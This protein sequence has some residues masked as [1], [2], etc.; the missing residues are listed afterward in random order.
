MTNGGQDKFAGSGDGELLRQYAAGGREGAF[1]EVVRRHVDWVY[2]AAV[3]VTRDPALAEDVT[4]GVFVALARKAGRLAR[5]PAVTGWLFQAVRYGAAAAVRRER[6]RRRHEAQAMMNGRTA[7]GA[8]DGREVVDWDRVAG[9]L[10]AA[11]ARLREGDREAI[12]LRYYRRLNWAEVGA[13]LGVTEDAARMRVARATGRLRDRLT[14]A[15][16][17]VGAGEAGVGALTAGLLV[18]AVETAPAR[19]AHVAAGGGAVGPGAAAVSKGVLAMTAGKVQG[20]A[21][22]VV[23]AALAAGGV[24]V[25][26]GGGGVPRPATPAAVPAG[27]VVAATASAALPVVPIGPE[28]TVI[29]GPLRADGRVDY[30]AALNAR[31]GAGVT[32]ENNGYVLWLKAVGT[33]PDS[34][35][36]AVREQVLAMA[37]AAGAPAGDALVRF[38]VYAESHRQAGGKEGIET[39][40]ALA[41]VPWREADAPVAAAYL[42]AYDGVLSAAAAAVRRPRWWVP[43]VAEDGRGLW[44]ASL[45]STVWSSCQTVRQGLLARATRRLAAGDF[46][47]FRGDVLSARWVARR[48]AETPDYVARTFAWG[49]DAAA[50]ETVA[51]MAARGLFSAAECEA[52]ATDFDG[53]PP[54]AGLAEAFDVTARWRVLDLFAAGKY[55]AWEDRKG[56]MMNLVDTSRF[57]DGESHSYS[58]VVHTRREGD[59]DWAAA[60]RGANKAIDEALQG[61]DAPSIAEAKRRGKELDR[62]TKTAWAAAQADGELTPAAGESREAYSERFGRLLAMEMGPSGSRFWSYRQ[63]GMRTVMARVLLGAAGVKARTGRWPAAL[64]EVPAAELGVRPA[65]LAHERVGYEVTPAGPRVFLLGGDGKEEAGNRNSVGAVED[66]PVAAPAQLP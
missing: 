37:G 29:S 2:S 18:H 22:G 12:L 33:G 34:M 58:P 19:V 6:V 41:Q 8:V 13:A 40:M 39:F 61:F 43:A 55:E 5:H 46:D 42:R 64:A 36:P 57:K 11:V 45:L 24:A 4:Q 31:Y 26:A 60:M 38:D 15:G 3:R 47:G 44:T 7:G 30:V 62:K 52:L 48:L 9:A 56:Q 1:A 16:C 10:E 23:V 20:V 59:V 25:V 27:P 32:P 51:A 53:L 63:M 28:T 54:L 35:E 21:A 65:L 14:A 50:S 17:E 49:D 66:K